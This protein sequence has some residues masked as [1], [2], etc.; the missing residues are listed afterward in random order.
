MRKKY[1]LLTALLASL[2]SGLRAQDLQANV[3]V[4]AN[5]IPSTVDHKV[6]NTLQTSLFN[7]I[8]GRKWANEA[9]QTNERIICNFLVNISSAGD[10]NTYK[11]TLTVQA[12]RP[13][14]NSSYQS[15]SINIQDENF[16]F[17]YV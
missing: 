8:N 5:R 12:G 15:P 16:T 4:I 11:A 17:R 9:F 6:F 10:N 2:L 7:F 1:L 14:Y 3:S 13:V